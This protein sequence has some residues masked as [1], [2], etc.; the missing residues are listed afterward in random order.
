MNPIKLDE[1]EEDGEES[2]RSEQINVVCMYQRD[3]IGIDMFE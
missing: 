2:L 3:I 1:A